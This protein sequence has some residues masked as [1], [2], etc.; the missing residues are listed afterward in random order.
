M[1]CPSISSNLSLV[2]NI[3]CSG[4]NL[5]PHTSY[6]V[7]TTGTYDVVVVDGLANPLPSNP[8]TDDSTPLVITTEGKYV[9]VTDEIDS[10]EHVYIECKFLFFVF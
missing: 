8:A 10:K 3:T 1:Q 7:I 4:T 2:E 6:S 9:S 5:R